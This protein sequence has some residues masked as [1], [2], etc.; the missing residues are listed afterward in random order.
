[1]FPACSLSR[2]TLIFITGW[3]RGLN[4][5]FPR[6]NY[7][8]KIWTANWLSNIWQNPCGK[9]LCYLSCIGCCLMNCVA[10]AHKQSAIRSF[11]QINYH[12]LQVFEMVR[13]MLW[14]PGFSGR[15]MAAEIMRDIFW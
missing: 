6:A 14:C 12:P 3:W 15:R 2:I 5:S 4:V 10:N 11:F 7:R 8:V 9:C 13:P 1:M